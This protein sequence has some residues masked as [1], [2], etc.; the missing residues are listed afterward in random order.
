MI[1]NMHFKPITNTNID[2]MY[3]TQPF[4]IELSDTEIKKN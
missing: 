4:K 2:R 3:L 1:L